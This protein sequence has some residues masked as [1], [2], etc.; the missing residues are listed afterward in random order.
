MLASSRVSDAATEVP[1]A[2]LYERARAGD[3]AE[4]FWAIVGLAPAGPVEPLPPPITAPMIR[5]G[6]P[7]KID[8]TALLRGARSVAKF[9][10]LSAGLAEALERDLRGHGLRTLRV[11]P[12]RKRFDLALAGA[13]G[14]GE[15]LRDR[16]VER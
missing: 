8:R 6:S 9:E 7:R 3:G 12:Y 15:F 10:D 14:Q 4:A 2:R 13:Y 16:L 5:Y 11:G 1:L